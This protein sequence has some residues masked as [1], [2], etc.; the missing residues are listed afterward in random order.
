MKLLVTSASFQDTPGSHMQLLAGQGYDTTFLKGP[1][2]AAALLNA[3][4]G[5][6][7]LLC[8][9]DEI[10]AEVLSRGRQGQLK[11]ISKYGVGVDN[12][13]VIKARQLNITVTNCPGV[14]QFAVAELVFCLLLAFARNICQEN[15]IVQAGGWQ[16]LTGIE[17][18]NKTIGIVGFGAVG[19]EVA[20]RAKAFGMQVLVNTAHPPMGYFK[21]NGYTL[22]TSIAELANQADFI[23]LHLPL[24]ALTK[25]LIDKNM[26]SVLKPGAIIINTAR[27][28][29]VDTLAIVQGLTSGVIGGYLADVLDVEPM[30]ANHPFTQLPNVLITPHIGSRT[31]QSVERQGVMAV[32]NLINMVTGN[33]EAYRH[34]LV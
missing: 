32:E 34:H 21:E 11:F 14:N 18:Y 2:K 29:L 25:G 28:G 20:K 12:I 4:A 23:S 1:L 6:D 17:I 13:D 33:E 15:N 5:Y 31:Y 19:R 26:V 7:A 30:P 3:I 10:T 8:G 16:K 22:C 24:T 27:G 9:D